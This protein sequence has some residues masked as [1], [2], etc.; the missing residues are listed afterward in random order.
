MVY[1]ENCLV[2]SY[3]RGN[4]LPRTV[5]AEESGCLAIVSFS[6]LADKR[7]FHPNPTKVLR[8]YHRLFFNAL[9]CVLPMPL[10]IVSGSVRK[11]CFYHDPDLTWMKRFFGRSQV[12]FPDDNRRYIKTI[13]AAGDFLARYFEAKPLVAKPTP[14]R[15]IGAG[16]SE[17][18][19]TPLGSGGQVENWIQCAECAKWRVVSKSYLKKNKAVDWHCNIR[20]SPVPLPEVGRQVDRC[21]TEEL[22]RW[23]RRSTIC[24]RSGWTLH[25]LGR[26]LY[27]DS[28]S[29]VRS[30][31]ERAHI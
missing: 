29:L 7:L 1:F 16:G 11:R 5:L 17:A 12:G 10:G 20:G 6:G 26:K 2:S 4:V 19:K 14:K 27:A 9:G 28:N 25:I 23:T 8:E 31:L 22:H 3:A 21:G 30:R 18:G 13:D 15:S 24:S